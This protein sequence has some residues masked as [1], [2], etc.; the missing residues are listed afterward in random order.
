MVHRLLRAW[1][2]FQFELLW[3]VVCLLVGLPLASGLAPSPT[4]VNALLPSV[5][6]VI[7]G[8]S[9]TLGGGLTL[10]GILWRHIDASRFISGLYVERAGLVMLGTSAAVFVIVIWFYAGAPTLFV[11]AIYGA[12]IAAC[13]SRTKSIGMEI[14]IIRE[15]GGTDA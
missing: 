9:L 12:F 1:T 14:S 3:A 2:G 7:W 15:H 8:M 13:I 5:L 6:R 10:S 11:A 4:S